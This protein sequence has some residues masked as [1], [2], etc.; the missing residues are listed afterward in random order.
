METETKI[1]QVA[2][3]PQR[4]LAMPF[5]QADAPKQET[6]MKIC[7]SCSQPRPYAE[8]YTT[9]H[10]KFVKHCKSCYS[11]INRANY[12]KSVANPRPQVVESKTCSL[13]KQ[14]LGS[15][16]FAR[17]KNGR[18]MAACKPCHSKRNAEAQKKTAKKSTA[19]NSAAAPQV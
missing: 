5:V 4:A 19:S 1:E 15:E 9:S 12:L 14:E 10:G 18:L 8:Y 6:G 2:V 3:D 13:C 11:A 16:S 17:L 7:G